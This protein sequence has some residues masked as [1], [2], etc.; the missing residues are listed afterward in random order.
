MALQVPYDFFKIQNILNFLSK[1]MLVY[2]RCFIVQFFH[3]VLFRVVIESQDNQVC[4]SS[5]SQILLEKA[6]CE[7][8]IRGKSL[9][10]R[11]DQ[12]KVQARTKWKKGGSQE[13]C[14]LEMKEEERLGQLPSKG[15]L[16]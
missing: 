12:E 6:E 9:F 4:F 8:R 15:E 2:I 14:Q 16:S 5:D 10:G 7:A 3:C 1:R 13:K 11:E